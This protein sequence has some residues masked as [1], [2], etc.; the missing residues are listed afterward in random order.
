MTNAI[1]LKRSYTPGK[2]PL[3]SE[4]LLGEV[5]LNI[6]DGKAYFKQNTGTT[7]S[8]VEIMTSTSSGGISGSINVIDDNTNSAPQYLTY[9]DTITGSLSALKIGTT[10]LSFVPST[11]TLTVNGPLVVNNPA[12]NV[13]DTT[14][15]GTSALNFYSTGSNSISSAI[16]GNTG[17]GSMLGGTLSL[18]GNGVTSYGKLTLNYGF[19]IGATTPAQDPIPNIYMDKLDTDDVSINIGG[20]FSLGVVSGNQT[21]Y[22][23]RYDGG[24]LTG[25]PISVNRTTGVT[26]L[27]GISCNR[28]DSVNSVITSGVF[29][30]TGSSVAISHYLSVA[31]FRSVEYTLTISTANH[32]FQV[33]KVL[34]IHDDTA[35]WLTDYGS[36]STSNTSLMNFE[37]DLSTGFIQL[38]AVPTI[39]DII[40]ISSTAIATKKV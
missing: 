31:D 4:L 36:V 6:Y 2:V 5:G 35:S 25:T 14:T 13:G 21:F 26:S 9:T 34:V 39:S 32:G 33:I 3:T 18:I 7:E 15:S 12:I 16:H 8:I 11:G 37:C 29:T 24:I 28:I 10:S 22:I 27:E 17:N 38:L 19:T 20:Q 23:N 40:S 30:T 1:L